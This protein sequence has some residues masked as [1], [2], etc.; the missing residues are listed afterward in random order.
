MLF[1]VRAMG[2]GQR[3]AGNGASVSTRSGDLGPEGPTISTI[4]ERSSSPHAT[5][6]L[7]FGQGVA[8]V[9]RAAPGRLARLRM[10][11]AMH[12]PTVHAN[13]EPAQARLAPTKPTLHIAATL[14][15]G[16]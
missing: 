8:R 9:S 5:A 12:R 3:D 14:P 4:G 7:H 10:I 11:S 16:R 2:R 15:C 1:V 13:D 6:L